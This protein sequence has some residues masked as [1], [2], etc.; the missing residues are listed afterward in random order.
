MYL[1]IIIWLISISGW[2]AIVLTSSL[3]NYFNISLNSWNIAILSFLFSLLMT[4]L[5]SPK[6]SPFS[7]LLIWLIYVKCEYR[8]R[9]LSYRTSFSDKLFQ[10]TR[11][12]G[13][14]SRYLELVEAI[15]IPG[16]CSW[17]CVNIFLKIS[18]GNCVRE[19]Y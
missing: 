15:S 5:S 9:P 18:T 19:A 7:H 13:R 6:I 16:L 2:G 10:R 17:T 12:A 3:Y 11:A 1:L 14:K 8:W 4:S